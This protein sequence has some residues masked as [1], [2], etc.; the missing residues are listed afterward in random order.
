MNRRLRKKKRVGEFQELG[1]EVRAELRPGA[2]DGDAEAFI[3]RL[4]EVVEA[5]ELGFGGG[6]G[7]DDTFEGFVTRAGRGSATEDDRASLA[8]FLEG[9]D[10]VT[11]HEL[12]ELRDAWH[13]W[14]D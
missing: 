6:V 8:T 1:F 7:R 2:S 11:R 9:D 13:G 12:G 4:I 3:E 5:R 14:E 10:A